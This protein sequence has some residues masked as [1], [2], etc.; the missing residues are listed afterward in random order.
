[1]AK[2]KT[3]KTNWTDLKKLLTK[4]KRE[5][6]NSKMHLNSLKRALAFTQTVMNF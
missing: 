1:M 4:W 6:S 2:K 5:L 3:S